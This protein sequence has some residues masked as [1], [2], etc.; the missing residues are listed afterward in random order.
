M[1]GREC[2]TSVFFHKGTDA[3]FG[4][5]VQAQ[6]PEHILRHEGVRRFRCH[7]VMEG[8]SFHVDGEGCAHCTAI[9]CCTNCLQEVAHHDA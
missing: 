7:A 6:V 1:L 8:G 5:I 2:F 9:G 4:V 3:S